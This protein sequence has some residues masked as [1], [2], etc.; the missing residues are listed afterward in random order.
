MKNYRKQLKDTQAELLAF[1]TKAKELIYTLAYPKN[2]GVAT[3][4]AA[5][6]NG[7]LNGLT[8]VELLAIANMAETTDERIYLVPVTTFQGKA[9]Q[10][11]AEKHRPSVNVSSL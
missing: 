8:V 9:I 2:R 6:P 1:R 11:V 10:L 7:K 4:N 5:E 3:I